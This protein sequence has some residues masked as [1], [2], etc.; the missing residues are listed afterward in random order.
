MKRTLTLIILASVWTGSTAQTV[1]DQFAGVWELVIVENR[2]EAGVWSQDT[3]R[4][5]SAPIGYI[6]YDSSG[7]M[8]V[9]INGQSRPLFPLGSGPAGR[10]GDLNAASLEQLR[11]AIYGYTAYFGT[12]EVNEDDRTVTHRQ[13][14]H[15]R[16]N[17]VGTSVRRFYRFHDEFLTL[18]IP[19]EESRVIWKRLSQ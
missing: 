13:A 12:Y 19:D 8:S 18:T 5:G 11:A 9:Q 7:H 14:G 4:Y 16:P 3:E 6:A 10:A 17:N 2:D 15:I 1:K